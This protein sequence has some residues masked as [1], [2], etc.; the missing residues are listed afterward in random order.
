ME[1]SNSKNSLRDVTL[2]FL[3]RQK[4]P[5]P[6]TYPRSHHCSTQPLNKEPYEVVYEDIESC[7]CSLQLD[8]E[9][10]WPSALN[11]SR[12]V[13]STR[14][15]TGV[16]DYSNSCLSWFPFGRSVLTEMSDSFLA[17]REIDSDTC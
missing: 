12:R 8:L 13:G 14:S 9:T 11:L 16:Q 4:V 1:N 7:C 6:D 2:S 15:V 3:E 5:Q 10:R 17:I